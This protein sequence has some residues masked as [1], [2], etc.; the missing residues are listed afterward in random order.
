MSDTTATERTLKPVAYNK[1]FG[2]ELPIVYSDASGL[3]VYKDLLKP[4]AKTL[5]ARIKDNHQNTILIEGRTGSGKST[6]AIELCYL[7]EPKWS[8]ED[9][10]IYS[11]NDLKKKLKNQDNCSPISLL[12]EGSVSLNS[13][14]S[15][16]TD[17]KR[18][19]VLMDTCRSLGW[20][21]LICIPNRNDLNKRI[22]ENHIDF[23]IKCPNEPVIP[24]YSKRGF[25]TLYAH[26]YRD[27]CS[28]YWHPIGITIFNKMDKK[29][30][31]LYEKIKKEHQMELINKFIDEDD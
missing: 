25:C 3:V 1:Y 27:W 13:N 10:Y 20:T 18:L 24:G 22:R 2:C 14:N 19:T 16:R 15:Q 26:V 21:T 23:L 9:N 7:L 31:T 28:D 8:L 6:A 4:F 5:K 12:D 30:Q 17:D 11:A 29:T